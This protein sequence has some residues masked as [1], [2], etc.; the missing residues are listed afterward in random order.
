MAKKVI[1]LV[2]IL[3]AVLLV[4]YL[5]FQV[6]NVAYPNYRIEIAMI[7][8]VEDTVSATGIVVRDEVTIE[9]YTGEGVC[10]YLVANGEKVGKDSVV[11]EIFAAPQDALDRLKLDILRE[12]LELLKQIAAGNRTAGSNPS[13]ISDRIN[14]LLAEIAAGLKKNQENQLAAWRIQLLEL[15]NSYTLARGGQVD[16]AARA[17]EVETEIAQLASR[18]L[19]PVRTIKT[20]I[21]GYFIAAVDGLEDRVDKSSVLIMP[22]ADLAEMVQNTQAPVTGCKIISDYVWYYAAIIDQ[23][24]AEKF[25]KDAALTLDFGYAGITG[26]PVTVMGV[27]TDETTGKA[28]IVLACTRF[29]EVLA[30]LRQEDAK[31]SFRNYKGIII[32]RSALRMEKEVMGV[33]VKYGNVVAFR[34]VD[35]IYQA[36]D[37]IVSRAGTTEKNELA[38]Y[39]EIIVSGR[40]LSVGKRLN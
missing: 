25:K 14:R 24:D 30:G 40:D 37:Y 31:I 35:P 3:L 36:S 17:A 21:D 2:S 34:T 22:V 4:I 29:D 9:G 39:D 11:A 13:A 8:A 1:K 5:G 15:L 33:Y 16:V 12:E 10:H 20:P 18:D 27:S 6:Y 32:K 26:L 38:L 19:T 7:S 28:K 23:S